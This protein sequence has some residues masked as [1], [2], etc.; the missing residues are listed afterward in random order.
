MA[1]ILSEGQGTLFPETKLAPSGGPDY[2]GKVLLNG[3][4]FRIAAWSR[5]GRTGA[6]FLSLKVERSS[7]SEQAAPLEPGNTATLSHSTTNP[8]HTAAIAAEPPRGGSGE[9]GLGETSW[10][11]G[12]EHMLLPEGVSPPSDEWAM[13]TFFHDKADRAELL[14]K[15]PHLAPKSEERKITT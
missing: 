4:T 14:K 3:Q 8:G 10:L 2:S 7:S 1:Y 13:D 6:P 9:P 11:R 12:S 5:C 15:H